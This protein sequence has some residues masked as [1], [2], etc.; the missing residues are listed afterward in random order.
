MAANLFITFQHPGLVSMGQKVLLFGQLHSMGY[1]IK[2]IVSYF[3]FISRLRF[4]LAPQWRKGELAQRRN[5]AKRHFE[6]RIA[7]FE[8][9]KDR[10]WALGAGRWGKDK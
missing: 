9:D 3:S 6:S 8:F 5:D 10:H 4:R 1:S 2:A 7:N